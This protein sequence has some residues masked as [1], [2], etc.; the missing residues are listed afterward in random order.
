MQ[1]ISNLRELKKKQYRLYI[2]ILLILFFVMTMYTIFWCVSFGR[3]YGTFEETTA[4]CVE[5][6]DV[7]NEVSGYALEYYDSKNNVTIKNTSTDLANKNTVDTT[8]K[9][10]Y[11]TENPSSVVRSLGVGRIL[12]PM[13]TSIFGVALVILVV[14][15]IITFREMHSTMQTHKNS[16]DIAKNNKVMND[17]KLKR[18]SRKQVL[19][20]IKNIVL[21]NKTNICRKQEK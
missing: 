10:Y 21:K 19:S 4:K 6:L 12:L 17:H 1:E 2:Y 18:E 9:V 15:Y 5:I 20:N 3:E 16:P 7:D 8:F 13:L 14:L 11:D